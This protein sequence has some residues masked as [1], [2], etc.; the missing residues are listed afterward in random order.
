[1]SSES[2]VINSDEIVLLAQ[3]PND[4]KHNRDVQRVEISTNEIKY[5]E[6]EILAL[7]LRL[8]FHLLL[9]HSARRSWKTLSGA[10]A[11]QRVGQCTALLGTVRSLLAPL[12]F[13]NVLSVTSG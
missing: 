7:P 10:A 12:K 8:F 3:E 6:W 9:Y 13:I 2:S 4:Q 1:M 11:A 5:G